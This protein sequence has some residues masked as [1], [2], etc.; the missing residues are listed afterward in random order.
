MTIYFR[1]LSKSS[2]FAN[3]A[4][5]GVT[6]SDRT[7]QFRMVN[8]QILSG[9]RKNCHSTKD[10]GKIMLPCFCQYLPL[11]GL[12][13]G[14]NST[15]YCN[16]KFRNSGRVVNLWCYMICFFPFQSL[17]DDVNRQT[18]REKQL[19][20][21]YAELQ[22]ELEDLQKRRQPKEAAKTSEE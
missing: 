19:Q 7:S 1:W 2:G 11:I 20:K 5:P 6:R 13:L 15:K 14:P 10:R 17:T 22:S 21:R 8:I 4:V 9:A 3:Q 18:D 16:E 12:V